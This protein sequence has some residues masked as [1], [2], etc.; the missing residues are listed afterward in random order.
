MF[1]RIQVLSDLLSQKREKL[2]RCH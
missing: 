1:V 2:R